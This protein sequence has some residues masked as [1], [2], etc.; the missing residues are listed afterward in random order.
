MPSLGVPLALLL[1]VFTNLEAFQILFKFYRVQSPA[2]VPYGRLVCGA[3]NSNPL[4]TLFLVNSP[5]LKFPRCPSQSHLISIKASVRVEVGLM[6]Y[7]RHSY[8]SGNTKY[9]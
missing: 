3:G 2:L 7:K 4:V 5:I 6:N 9:F 8:H 1:N